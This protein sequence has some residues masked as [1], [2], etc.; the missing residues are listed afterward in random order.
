M[1]IDGWQIDG[2][3]LLKD[4][5]Q[6]GLQPGVT[7][8]LGE[9][10]TGKS[11]LLAFVRT[12]LFGFPDGRSRQLT[13][14]PVRGGRHGGRLMVRDGQDLLWT[15]QR[16][17]D[18]RRNVGVTRPDGSAGNPGDLAALLGGADAQ[19]F[20]N[21]FAFGLD[22]LQ[23]FETL[24]AEGV[25]ERIFDAGI[26]GAG[27]SAR[28]VMRKLGQR[29]DELLKQRG[30][31]AAINNVVR[32]VNE[33]TE[34][35]RRA[36]DLVGHYQDRQR[37]ERE[38]SE[39]AEG[40]RR[41]VDGLL[42]RKADLEAFKEL[43]PQWQELADKREELAGL[44]QVDD[45]TL[46]DRVTGLVRD[47]DRLRALEGTAEEKEAA[48][49]AEQQTL[50]AATA[51]LGPG[52][53]VERVNGFDTSLA[54]RDE[55]RGW[56]GKIDAA[57]AA[58]DAAERE[59]VTADGQVRQ[60]QAAADRVR[61]ELPPEEPLAVDDIDRREALLRTLRGKM[62]DLDVLRLKA[63]QQAPAS[64]LRWTAVALLA[65]VV[66]V[67][68]IV[69]FVLGYSQLGVGLAVAGALLALV[70][71]LLARTQP[72]AAGGAGAEP[73]AVRD[74]RAALAGVAANLGL[75]ES[76]AAADLG[77]LEA[78]LRSERTGRAAWDD[79]Q[80][81]I[82]EAD[83]KVQDARLTLRGAGEAQQAARSA[84]ENVMI[85]WSCW[86]AGRGLA[87]L[88]PA[89]VQETIEWVEK[90][91][92]ASGRLT[93]AVQALAAVAAQ[94]RV[95][96][97]SA[98]AVLTATGRPADG[99]G[100]EALRS[101]VESLDG[102]LHR[103][104][105]L[106]ESAAALDRAIS[107]RLGSC[108]DH[109]AA[110]DELDCGAAEVWQR[111]IDDLEH[112]IA[113]LNETRD[114]T[115]EA[116]TTAR[117][118]I[119]AIESSVDIP[120]LQEERESLRAELAALAHN[121]RVASTA[122]ALIESTLKTFVRDRQP[123]VLDAGGR[124]FSALTGSRYTRVEQDDELSLQSVVVVAA[125]GSRLRPEVLSKGTQ[126]Q[127]YLAIRLALVEEFA[128][129]TEPLPLIMD[130]CLVNF[131]PR[132]A[133][134]VAA[135]LAERS[136]AHQCLLFTCHPETADLMARQT[137]GPVTV[138]EMPGLDRQEALKGAGVQVELPGT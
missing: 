27:K 8:L 69:T 18:D 6:H 50:D 46:P 54:V 88:T 136:A 43:Q 103:R 99:M 113:E 121:Y 74:A 75:P 132:R 90:A 29:Q 16:Y 95:W 96:D 17:G 104:T 66:L 112:R 131:D 109:L 83:R 56:A 19:L 36:L 10:E 58:L 3:G 108:T 76:P 37:E 135:L 77:V 44:P 100:T 111:E 115:I 93:A 5:E 4:F 1:R 73:Q 91:R 86:L 85:E 55:V 12:M 105:G 110:R 42:R 32:A 45:E 78:R 34:E 52:W 137:A 127:L 106:I 97:E 11:T 65:A 138:I 30:G 119:A 26:S 118:E 41:Q 15:I 13:Y 60:A 134:A 28:E 120:R 133:A 70:A 20:R 14:D 89:G 101:A 22:E 92:A 9:N 31:N 79:A 98:R 67:G 107:V 81:R 80:A 49:V 68:C 33:K 125:D 7:V 57:R 62:N 102:D 82:R 21:V 23:A 25:G 51:Q 117:N 39:A 48:C 122:D 129:R 71:A 72:K 128:Q 53:D 40:L 35:E 64:G 63:E 47:L 38:Q 94:A 2:F 130:D 114:Q 59:R 87:G 126:Q 116:A 123:A 124:A 61:G 24:S 84:H